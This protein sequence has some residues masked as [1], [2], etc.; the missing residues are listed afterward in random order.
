MTS[1]PAMDN[2][3]LADRRCGDWLSDFAVTSLVQG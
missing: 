3:T 1:A 2:P